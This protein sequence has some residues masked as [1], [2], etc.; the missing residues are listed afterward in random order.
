MAKNGPLIIVEDDPDDQGIL[1]EIIRETGVK[2]ELI[3][4][5]NGPAAFDFLISSETQP[6]L[7]LSDVN[8][9]IQSGIEF[10]KQI[11]SNPYL[12]EKS[13]PFVFFSTSVEKSA[14]KT[15]YTQMTVQGF[16]KK[17]TTY[18]DIRKTIAIIMEYWK[19][20]KHPNSD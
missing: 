8:L 19:L 13:I 12:R 16:F 3:F 17:E 6:F 20:C 9:P 4:F 2:N 15:A 10:K 5:T 11:D 14:V 18:N 7:I 1:E